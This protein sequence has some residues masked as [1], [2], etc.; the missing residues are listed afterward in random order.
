MGL[1]SSKPTTDADR[2]ASA[3]KVQK[4]LA[5]ARRKGQGVADTQ[6]QSRAVIAARARQA[7]GYT[8]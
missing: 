2:A 8:K 4:D 1:F 7:A 3:E 6:R 5:K